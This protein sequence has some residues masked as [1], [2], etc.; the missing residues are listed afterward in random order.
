MKIITNT[1]MLR[2]RC[3]SMSYKHSLWIARK[4]KLFLL[5]NKNIAN[6]TIGLACNQLGLDG[7]VIIIKKNNKWIHLINPI[8]TKKSN[9]MITTKEECLSVPGKSISVE[10][11]RS[12][13]I[14]HNLPSTG[15]DDLWYYYPSAAES[16][17]IQHE[18][19]HLDGIIITD[20]E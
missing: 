19:D 5:S 2:R 4:M 15:I 8:I 3:E 20:K 11:H 7:R 14:T 12:I 18:I 13:Q 1:D 16:I 10:R 6:K 9:D 17:V